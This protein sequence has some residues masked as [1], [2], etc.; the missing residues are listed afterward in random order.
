[1]EFFTRRRWTTGLAQQS[2]MYGMV[3]CMCCIIFWGFDLNTTAFCSGR[4]SLRLLLLKS[5][6]ARLMFPVESRFPLEASATISLKPDRTKTDWH[7]PQCG[8]Q[9]WG[10]FVFFC[11]PCLLKHFFPFKKSLTKLNS[12]WKIFHVG[13]FTAS[14]T[15]ILLFNTLD[16]RLTNVLNKKWPMSGFEPRI[17]G[18]KSDRSTNWAT[19]TAHDEKLYRASLAVKN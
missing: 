1:M 18:V 5:S 6:M 15:Y 12:W 9:K 2:N 11:W 16:N 19:T 3:P 13:P 10:Q 4:Y 14:L 7:W 8:V 17:S